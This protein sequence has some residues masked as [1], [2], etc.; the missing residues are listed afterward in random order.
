MFLSRSFNLVLIISGVVS[1]HP[2]NVLWGQGGPTAHITSGLTLPARCSYKSGDVFVRIVGA[3]G[4]PYYCSATNTWSTFTG[5]DFSTTTSAQIVAKFSGTCN[6][7]TVLV[8]DG[9]CQAV[10][11]AFSAITNGTNTTAAMHVG[12]GSSLD[13]TGSGSVTATA[14]PFSGISAG[15][16]TNALVVGNSGSLKPT[17]TGVVQATQLGGLLTDSISGLIMNGGGRPQNLTVTPT[18]ATGST[19]WTYGIRPVFFNGAAGDTATAVSI[20]NGNA[21]LNGTNYN[22]LSWSAFSGAVSYQIFRTVAGGTP[23]TTGIIATVG[24]TTYSDQGAA[25]DST[26]YQPGPGPKLLFKNSTSSVSGTNRIEIDK[27]DGTVMSSISDTGTVLG[28]QIDVSPHSVGIN[29]QGN[30]LSLASSAQAIWSSTTDSGGTQ[31]VGLARAAAGVLKVTDGSSNLA[32]I[33]VSQST[34]T[35]SSD[36]CTAGSIWADASYIYACTASGTIKRV[37]LS[38]F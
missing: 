30:N 9:S 2:V 15:T 7:G 10:S 23:S 5:T 3:T 35:A 11:S 37:A 32:K 20:S 22:A 8:G 27:S 31:D 29:R 1:L 18:G 4:T 17:G 6:A 14:A 16:N 24:T 13:A 12:T 36:A 25:G 21:T 33:A 19:T 26:T 34:P 38:T 28:T